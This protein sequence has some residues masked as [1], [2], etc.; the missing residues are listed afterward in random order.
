MSGNENLETGTS[1]N[2]VHS[3]THFISFHSV[4]FSVSFN[5]ISFI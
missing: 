2:E 4:V 5:L 3:I 1:H